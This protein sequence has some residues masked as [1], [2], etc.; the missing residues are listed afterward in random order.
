MCDRSSF[1]MNLHKGINKIKSRLIKPIVGIT[2]GDV[3]GIGPEVVKK[4]LATHRVHKVCLPI[5]IGEPETLKVPLGRLSAKA[6]EYAMQCVRSAAA[7]AINGE[8]DAIVT[9]PISKGGIHKAGYKFEGHTDYLAYLTGAKEYSMM[10]VSSNLKVLLVTIHLKLKDVAPK[11]TQSNVK[12]AV[13]HAKMAAGILKIKKPRIAVCALN[14]HGAEIGDEEKK[15]ILPAIKNSGVRNVKGPF[16]ADTL[17]YKAVNN[18]F[19]IVIAMYHDQG[20]IPVKMLGFRDAVNVTVGLPFIRT[21]PDHGTAYDIAG[22]NKADPESMIRAIE[23]AAKMA[24][25]D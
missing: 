7:M 22:R 15:I 8:I 9:A 12:R 14:P 16:P 17:F 10:F 5:V 23:L 24:C 19:D 13:R 25:R 3:A 2:I 18:E 4:A 11:I 1:S 21:S 20:L 6:G